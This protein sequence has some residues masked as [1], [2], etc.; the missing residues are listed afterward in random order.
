[1]SAWTMAPTRQWSGKIGRGRRSAPAGTRVVVS[2]RRPG[3]DAVRVTARG[4]FVLLVSALMLVAFGVAT[5]TSEPAL[6]SAGGSTAG[7]GYVPLSVPVAAESTVVVRSGDTLWSI[8]AR[9]FPGADPREAVVAFR[10]ANGSQLSS[11]QVGQRL[12]VPARL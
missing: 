5:V 4:R 7:Q 1:M 8:A 2:P 3:V 10:E 9:T 12:V 6:S 11:L